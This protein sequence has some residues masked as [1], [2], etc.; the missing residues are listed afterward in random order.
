M[1]DKLSNLFLQNCIR[2]YSIDS[3]IRLNGN[4]VVSSYIWIELQ[5]DPILLD[6]LKIAV[7]SLGKMELLS[8]LLCLKDFIEF[9]L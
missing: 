5:M 6:S 8:W 7:K 1:L 9:E 2:N 3:E 4:F